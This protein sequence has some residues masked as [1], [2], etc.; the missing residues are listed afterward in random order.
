MI[1]W[2]HTEVLALWVLRNTLLIIASLLD[3]M[4]LKHSS[5]FWSKLGKSFDLTRSACDDPSASVTG[6]FPGRCICLWNVSPGA[7]SNSSSFSTWKSTSLYTAII[8]A[9][10]AWCHLLDS[11]GENRKER[12][13]CH[14]FYVSVHMREAVDLRKLNFS[15]FPILLQGFL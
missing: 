3:P 10:E 12:N 8:T 1:V 14:Y 4:F 2:Y 11:W 6:T 9:G 7:A 5:D 13:S 15:T